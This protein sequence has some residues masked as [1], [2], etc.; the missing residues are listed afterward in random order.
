MNNYLIMFDLETGGLLPSQPTI[1]L[2]AIAAEE[3]TLREAG[4]AFS[5]KIVIEW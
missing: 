5:V 4:S 1:S 3:P 2:S